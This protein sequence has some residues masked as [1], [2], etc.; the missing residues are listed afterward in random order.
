MRLTSDEAFDRNTE[1]ARADSAAADDMVL[2]DVAAAIEAAD[3]SLAP[4]VV[5]VLTPHVTQV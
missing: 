1:L 4:G 2:S 3:A 5:A